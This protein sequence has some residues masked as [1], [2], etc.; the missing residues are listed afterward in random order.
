MHLHEQLDWNP[1]CCKPRP[2]FTSYV[3]PYAIVTICSFIFRL[4]PLCKTNDLGFL[5]YCDWFSY[6]FTS[7]MPSRGWKKVNN[8]SHNFPYNPQ[9]VLCQRNTYQ[10]HPALQGRGE[11]NPGDISGA[12]WFETLWIWRMEKMPYL[13][14]QISV[15]MISVTVRGNQ[16]LTKETFFCKHAL[17]YFWRFALDSEERCS[18]NICVQWVHVCGNTFSF[19]RTEIIL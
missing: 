11:D 19:G 13:W 8:L 4:T 2:Q 3:W 14:R 1:N 15:S 18:R 17:I 10:V 9:L 12:K 6:I 5:I 16:N 7:T